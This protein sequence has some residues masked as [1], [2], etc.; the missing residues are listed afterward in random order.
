M[1]QADNV[2]PIRP[3]NA[4]GVQTRFANTLDE[5]FQ[6]KAHRWLTQGAVGAFIARMR[7]E[8]LGNAGYQVDETEP[9]RR[10]RFE[11]REW[12]TALEMDKPQVVHLRDRL[13]E[14]GI[15]TYE[16]DAPGAGWLSWQIDTSRWRTTTRGGKREGAG[17]PA[18]NQNARRE[19]GVVSLIDSDNSAIVSLIDSKPAGVVSLI[20]SDEEK[21]SNRQRANSPEAGPQAGAG[22]TAPF[23]L[24][25][26]ISP[27]QK[28]TQKETLRAEADASGRARVGKSGKATMPPEERDYR[29]AL[30]GLIAQANGLRNARSLPAYD[31][32][33]QAAGKFYREGVSVEEVA[34]LYTVEARRPKWASAP[35]HL[36][37]LFTLLGVWRA[38]GRAEYVAG[39]RRSIDAK[40]GRYAQQPTTPPPPAR[41]RPRIVTADPNERL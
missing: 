8:S 33:W 24:D 38:H 3:T 16:Q 25:M 26:G 1:A 21:Q 12:A 22:P 9:A 35:L 29:A 6:R 10:A 14:R 41:A 23:F 2:T 11:L 7:R 20:D 32:Q 27:E 4:L 17:A 39:V 40:D 28:E 19:A 13:V 37:H 30:L 31:G 5:L 34:D 15:L 18:G 36:E